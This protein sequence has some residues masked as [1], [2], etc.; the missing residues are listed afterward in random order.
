MFERVTKVKAEFTE[1]PENI[2]ECK[3]VNKKENL[4][5]GLCKTHE[6]NGN[7]L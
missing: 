5:Q 2:M 7:I 1:K 4:L 3:G 6:Q